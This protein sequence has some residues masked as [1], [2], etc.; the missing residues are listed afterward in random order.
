MG[1]VTSDV[2]RGMRVT[3][4]IVVGHIAAQDEAASKRSHIALP[5]YQIYLHYTRNTQHVYGVNAFIHFIP[6][7]NLINASLG[8]II[9]SNTMDRAAL[10]V[11]TLK[12]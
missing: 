1:R 10:R 3:Q 6:T 11:I 7:K 4:F 9:R 8:H 2:V 5:L 12:G